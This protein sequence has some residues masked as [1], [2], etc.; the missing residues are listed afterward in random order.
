ME[1]TQGMGHLLIE[2]I[3][4]RHSCFLWCPA[5]LGNT[6]KQV[7][8]DHEEKLPNWAEHPGAASVILWRFTDTLGQSPATSTAFTDPQSN[9]RFSCVGCT[10]V[11]KWIWTFKLHF[12]SWATGTAVIPGRE[13]KGQ[14]VCFWS[15][16]GC[17]SLDILIHL[18][19][20][21]VKQWY[22]QWH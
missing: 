14:A 19:W 13:S 9:S 22:G 1:T 18:R 12:T 21:K 4:W 7:C 15:V 5:Q 17:S 3:L 16:V 20:L 11:G 6:W 10:L 2:R 8:L